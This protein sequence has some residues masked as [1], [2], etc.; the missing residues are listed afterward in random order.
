MQPHFPHDYEPGVAGEMPPVFSPTDSETGSWFLDGLV[1]APNSV[2]E[3]APAGYEAYVHL[4]HP[5]WAEVSSGTAGSFYDPP[6][7]QAGSG[8]WLKPIRRS[9]VARHGDG[10]GDGPHLDPPM[11]S[12]MGALALI[13]PLIGVLRRH[14]P[15]DMTCLCGFWK[16]QL[17]T[18][19]GIVMYRAEPAAGSSGPRSLVRYVK[20]MVLAFQARN[21]VRRMRRDMIAAATAHGSP[22]QVLL[23]RGSLDG[24]EAWLSDF[25]ALK[26]HYHPSVFW[27]EDRRWCVA[28]PQNKP[29]S[30]V[31]GTRGLVDDVLALTDIDAFEVKRSDDVWHI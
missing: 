30:I 23:Y 15:E 25:G 7:S 3:I 1:G 13:R 9:E 17:P 26:A 18:F 4:P 12:A 6:D 19:G 27:P 20:S 5:H 10:L 14:T 21:R 29:L 11:D 24:I 8:Y 2:G 28:M 31:A 16:V 22:G